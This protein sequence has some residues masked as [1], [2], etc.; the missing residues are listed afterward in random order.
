M[1]FKLRGLFYNTI[2]SIHKRLDQVFTKKKDESYYYKSYFKKLN[3]FK[4]NLHFHVGSHKIYFN[5]LS[6]SIGWV[7]YL[8]G[9]FEKKELE[10]CKE[11][12]NDKDIVLDI[13]ANIGSHS[14]YFADC[15]PNGK[16]IAFEPSGET[17]SYLNKNTAGISNIVVQ[18]L[19]IGN[20]NGFVDFYECDNDAMNGMKDTG[21]SAIKDKITTVCLK[22]DDFIRMI[23]LPKV[24]FIKIDVEGL[25]HQ[26][27][28]G[29]SQTIDQH[30]PII[31][32]EIVKAQNSNNDPSATIDYL[33]SKGYTVQVFNGEKLIDYTEH[34][35]NFYNYFFFPKN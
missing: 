4:R 19:A 16:V 29:L 35:D 30:K 31:F 27:L 1:N 7:G 28:E 5:P 34:K 33:I 32:C 22:G 17:L 13:G 11:L 25:E 23:N 3:F 10:I 20:F 15:T 24:D 21:R 2:S 9:E 6:S 18:Q 8:T 26:V 14:V 12:I